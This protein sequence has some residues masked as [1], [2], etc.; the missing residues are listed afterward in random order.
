MKCSVCDKNR[1]DLHPRK[2]KLIA[3]MTLLLCT[4]C[5]VN[6]REPRFLIVLYG[7]ANGLISIKDYIEN[8]RYIGAEITALEL[9]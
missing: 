3:G 6:N 8:H 1:S 4:D 5:R 2:S 7:R 9:A